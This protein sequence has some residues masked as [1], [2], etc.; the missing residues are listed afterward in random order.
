MLLQGSGRKTGGDQSVR[1]QT[2]LSETYTKEILKNDK[3]FPLIIAFL[4]I[5]NVLF[6]VGIKKM[7]IF[8]RAG[9]E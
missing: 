9:A 1:R 5:I 8:G 4:I 3:Q 2:P 6:V 7:N